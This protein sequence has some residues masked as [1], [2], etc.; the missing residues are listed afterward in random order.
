[1]TRS[2]ESFKDGTADHLLARDSFTLREG[3]EGCFELIV[4]S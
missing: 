4:G 3:G 2:F 1:V